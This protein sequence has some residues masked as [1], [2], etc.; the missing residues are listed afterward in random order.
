M[1]RRLT[2]AGFSGMMIALARVDLAERPWEG[3][4]RSGY[5]K[6][7][8]LEGPSK[9]ARWQAWLAGRLLHSAVVFAPAACFQAS[10]FEMAL[11]L[12][13]MYLPP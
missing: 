10:E 4:P 13:T 1:A 9:L 6:Y 2:L 7:R 11:L 12:P 8:Y 3:A 5:V